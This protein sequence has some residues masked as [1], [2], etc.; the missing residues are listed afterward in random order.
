MQR[1]VLLGSGFGSVYAYRRLSR[2]RKKYRKLVQ[3]TLVARDN[4]FL[5]SPLLHEVATGGLRQTDAVQ[6]IRE[7]IDCKRDRFVQDEVVKVNTSNRL[8]TLKSGAKLE[9]DELIVGL[10]AQP[11][12]FGVPGAKEN[13]L[14]LKWLSDARTI[15]N[16]CLRVMQIAT[17]K[18]ESGGVD[19][20]LLN[21]IV[22]GGGPTGIELATELVEFASSFAE[23]TPSF[24]LSKL[25]ISIYDSGSQVLNNFPEAVRKIALKNLHQLG[26]HT[27]LN[28]RINRVMSDGIETSSG[29]VKSQVVM[30]TAGV[31]PANVAISPAIDLVHG[32]VKVTDNLQI[33]GINNV[34]VVGDMAYVEGV[35]QLAQAAVKMGEYA[36]DSIAAGWKKTSISPFKFKNRGML[37]SLG[38][39]KS[40]GYVGP[41][42]IS[43]FIGW[44]IWRTVYLSKLLGTP[45]KL[46]T[47]IDWTIDIFYRRDLAEL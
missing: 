34:Y 5:F 40:A 6:P 31:E 26:I 4:Y 19:E 24:P 10:G 16:R 36:A 37:I 32:C 8:V 22:V 14:T 20:G 29:V 1:I 2:L 43:G 21:W 35:P 30:W 13:A 7:I 17:E 27:I 3:I 38:Q 9:Y 47:M 18:N 42:I 46:R 12:F 11:N 28:S 25:R 39:W 33:P 15:R 41:I 45:N 44:W 23:R